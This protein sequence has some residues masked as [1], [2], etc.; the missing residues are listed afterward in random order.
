MAY[1]LWYMVNSLKGS[2]NPWFLECPLSWALEL[3]LGILLLMWSW[4]PLRILM[5]PGKPVA[6]SNGLDSLNYGLLWSIVACG[7]SPLGNP[8]ER[9]P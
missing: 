4:G 7:L 1:S 2:Y 8:V 3:E 6:Y 5:V 9:T